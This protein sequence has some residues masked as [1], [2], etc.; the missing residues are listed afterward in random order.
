[1]LTLLRVAPFALLLVVGVGVVATKWSRRA[2]S[3][4]I[5]VFIGSSCVAGF[6]QRDVGTPR[7]CGTSA[8]QRTHH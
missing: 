7:A 3:A 4:F 2:V 6:A 5:A 1:M 8:G